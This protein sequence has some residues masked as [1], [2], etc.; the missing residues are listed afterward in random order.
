RGSV[1]DQILAGA[2]LPLADVAPHVSRALASRVAKAMAS[3]PADRYQTARE[4]HA[5]LGRGKLVRRAWQRVAPHN[6]HDRCWIERARL[7]G[8]TPRFQACV[9]AG[10]SGRFNL[11]C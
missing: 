6:G 9:V 1:P 8:G 5:A 2:Y 11:D 7:I 3:N 4:M 10:A